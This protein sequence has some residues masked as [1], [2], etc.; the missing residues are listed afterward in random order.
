MKRLA[1]IA[2]LAGVIAFVCTG[3]A[4]YIPAGGIYTGA[5]GAIGAGG[6]DVSYSKV[7]KATSTSILGL[8]ATGDA[9]IKTAAANG[10]IKRIKYVDYEV[11]NILGI[12]GQYTTVV[13]GD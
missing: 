12:Y 10:G 11:N 8:V 2:L 13:Y 5:Q 1:M 4:S 3:C 7:G 6:G 9:S